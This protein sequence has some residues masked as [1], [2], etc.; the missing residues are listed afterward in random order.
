MDDRRDASHDWTK[1]SILQCF[2]D[3]E[4]DEGLW[5]LMKSRPGGRFGNE[6]H[7]DFERNSGKR[8]RLSYPREDPKISPWFKYLGTGPWSDTTHR[9]GK[10]FRRRFRVPHAFFLEMVRECRAKQTFPEGLDAFGRCVPL[11]F[12]ILGVLRVLGRGVCFDDIAELTCTGEEVHRVFFH[13]FIHYYGTTMYDKHV[14]L[15]ES[16]EE[17][18]SSMNEYAKGGMNGAGFSMDCFHTW[19]DRCPQG[20]KV[21]FT[22]FRVVIPAPG[23]TS[24]LFAWTLRYFV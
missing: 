5:L 21:A 9:D 16:T 8:T 20:L 13:T 11:E 6:E 12:K 19:I 22:A 3:G 2:E 15:P 17:I 4:L 23:M 10:L 1:T 7:T 14:K 18:Q 24:L